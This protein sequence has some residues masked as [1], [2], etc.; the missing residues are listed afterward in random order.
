MGFPLLVRPPLLLA[1]GLCV[2]L[3]LQSLAEEGSFFDRVLRIFDDEEKAAPAGPDDVTYKVE[4]DA[5]K[6]SSDLKSALDDSSNLKALIKAPPGNA[7][8]LVRRAADDRIRLIAALYAYGYYG[9]SV[10]I[11]IAGMPVAQASPIAPSPFAIRRS[12]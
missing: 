5:G 10:T 9:G 4:I 2:F 3:P 11:E 8:G 1:A 12:P 7:A 6:A